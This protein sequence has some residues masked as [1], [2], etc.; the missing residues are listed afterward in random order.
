MGPSGLIPPWLQTPGSRP[1]LLL[2]IH[3]QVFRGLPLCIQ[4]PS[5]TR[6]GFA[7]FADYPTDYLD[8][9]AVLQDRADPVVLVDH[10]MDK[11]YSFAA[12]SE[13]NKRGHAFDLGGIGV[14]A[15]PTT[16]FSIYN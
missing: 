9:L 4:G 14:I 2:I 16:G 7:V 15:N 5:R 6:Q 8:L 11:S 13:K 3:S 1:R 10:R 12:F